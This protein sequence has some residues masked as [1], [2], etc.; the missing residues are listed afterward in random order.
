MS[1]KRKTTFDRSFRFADDDLNSKL[2][3]LLGATNVPFVVDER[4]VVHYP[5]AYEDTVENDVICSV[6]DAAF[7]SWQLL[8]CPRNWVR[9]YRA[10]MRAH[11]IPFRG[12]LI[13]EQESFLIPGRYQP[14]AWP[15]DEVVAHRHR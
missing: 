7:P 9:R 12:E 14:H 4:Y 3:S 6:R 1:L 11:R 5:S 10:F 2:L 13:D 15:L 8:S